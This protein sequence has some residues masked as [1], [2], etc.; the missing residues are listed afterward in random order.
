MSPVTLPKN[1]DAASLTFSQM[2][3]LKNGGKSVFINK[4]NGPF[5]I[6]TP[7]MSTPFGLSKF[8]QE[9]SKGEREKWTLQ[10]SIKDV[11]SNVAMANF[12]K[13][14]KDMDAAILKVCAENSK[15]WFKKQY[16]EEILRELMSPLIIYP[17]DKNTGEIT[18]KYPPM[19]RLTI[20]MV[21]GE[22]A[23]DCYNLQKE[24][25][26]L[27]TVD[28]GSKVRAILQCSGIWFIG[29]KFGLSWRV[30]Q[31]Q[32]A[33]P[34]SISGFA[35]MDDEEPTPAPTS[36]RKFIE[37]SD[38]E[39]D[40]LDRNPEALPEPEPEPEPVP[41]V[42]TEEP[43]PEQVDEPEPAPIEKASPPA[44]GKRAAKK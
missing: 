44:K 5:V 19:F 4:N 11:E 37:E 41:E 43:E 39:E 15:A 2:S 21:D 34:A 14:L 6:Q 24:K 29:S 17:K 30:V 26:S 28:K 9:E 20:P 38:D 7:L 18:D 22:I 42:E 13:L 27:S 36:S 12:Y 3:I 23:C 16:N 32:V 8:Q 35:F 40:L 1:V 31:L 25:V 10:L 33:P